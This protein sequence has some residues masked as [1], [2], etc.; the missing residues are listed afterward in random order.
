VKNP[1]GEGWI[2][3]TVDPLRPNCSPTVES[4]LPD[5]TRH[6]WID[7]V[8]AGAPSGTVDVSVLPGYDDRP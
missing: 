3:S 6:L 1:R 5:E 7:V 8:T 4:L 2:C